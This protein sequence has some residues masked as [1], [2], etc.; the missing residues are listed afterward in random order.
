[1]R[2]KV[3]V[4]EPIH[5]AG[6]AL[7]RG[8][9]D[10]EAAVT[11]DISEASLARAARDANGIIVRRAR[12]SRAVI[13]AAEAL[14]VVSRHGV[15]Y[16]ALDVEALTARGIPLV[17]AAGA[18]AVS[19]A[20]HTLSLVLALAKRTFLHDRATRAGRW[21]IRYELHAADVDGR[22]LLI[23]GLGRTGRLV[24][25]RALAFGM[26][27]HAYDPYVERSVIEAAGCV[28]V[29]DLHAVLP[30]MDVVTLHC[31]LTAETAG[32]IG[33]R[34]LALMKPSAFLVNCARGGI[35]DEPALHR[36]LSRG[37]LAGAGL[38]VF[39]VEPARPD[40]PLFALENVIAS[41]H[42]AGVTAESAERMALAAAR[43]VLAAFDGTLDP[44]AVVNPEVLATPRRGRA[45]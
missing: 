37:D 13:D 6:M 20:E 29:T 15:G 17:L 44:D 2:R 25:P 39:A 9:E 43:N 24:A 31:P 40:N 3:L 45:R 41:P 7:L 23:V 16:D 30:E 14:E 34:E 11:T 38:D 36:A 18:N 5:E 33:A 26:R 21:A 10:L 4:V 22:A 27:V 42:I 8:R 19:V 32:M 1:M 35:V 12:I 28:P